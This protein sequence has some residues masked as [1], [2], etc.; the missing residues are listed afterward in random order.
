MW[1]RVH[2]LSVRFGPN[3][4]IEIDEGEVYESSKT[5]TQSGLFLSVEAICSIVIYYC[6]LILYFLFISVMLACVIP[7]NKLLYTV[8]DAVSLFI[9]V[10]VHF[11]L[12]FISKYM[13]VCIY[14]VF[15]M[16]LAVL[17]FG[18]NI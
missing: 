4:P 16:L 18:M 8:N 2:V 13:W 12:C 15:D 14:E 7:S 3:W 1:Q 17:S 6:V 11:S 9:C 10:Y 5:G